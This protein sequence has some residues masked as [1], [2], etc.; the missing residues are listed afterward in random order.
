MSGPIWT[1][2]I[3]ATAGVAV[4]FFTAWLA[5]RLKISEFRQAWINDLRKDI[6]DYLGASQR[7]FNAHLEARAALQFSE[8]PMAAV[9]TPETEIKRESIIFIGRSRRCLSYAVL[10]KSVCQLPN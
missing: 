10:R 6:A 3:A 4:A 1:A 2:V 9:L 8:N 5:R 7:W